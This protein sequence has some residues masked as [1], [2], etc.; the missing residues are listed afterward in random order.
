MPAVKKKPAKKRKPKLTPY[1]KFVEFTGGKHELDTPTDAAREFSNDAITKALKIPSIVTIGYRY[2][3]RAEQDAAKRVAA[4]ANRPKLAR[5]KK[6][7][8]KN[9]KRTK[10]GRMDWR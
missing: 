7:N 10:Q 6:G 3:M 1:Q 2:R 5:D 9:A 4:H 8:V